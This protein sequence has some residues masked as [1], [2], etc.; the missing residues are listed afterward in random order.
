MFQ[1]T[2][3]LLTCSARLGETASVAYVEYTTLQERWHCHHW[4]LAKL[5]SSFDWGVTIFHVFCANMH[6]MDNWEYTVLVPY[7][8]Y[9]GSNSWLWDFE[10]QGARD[11]RSFESLLNDRRGFTTTYAPVIL[12]GFWRNIT[13]QNSVDLG[14]LS[15]SCAIPSACPYLYVIHILTY[16]RLT[17]LIH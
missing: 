7:V 8:D 1:E 10:S 15:G 12:Q 13:C 9:Q 4:W 14:R 6:G 11:S 5:V 17:F 16:A 3:T 2:A